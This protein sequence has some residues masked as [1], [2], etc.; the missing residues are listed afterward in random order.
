M[1]KNIYTGI[2]PEKK[3]VTDAQLIS[4]T[5]LITINSNYLLAACLKDSFLGKIRLSD[6]AFIPL[7]DYT[8]TRIST[9]LEIPDTK[10]SLSNIDDSIFIG[11]SKI[12]YFPLTD[13]TN[14]TNYVFKFDI[15]NKEDE[16]NG[17]LFESSEEIISF[18]F[19]NS[20]IIT[21]STRQIS[22]E[23]IRIKNGENNEY[24]LVCMHEG[25][26]QKKKTQWVYAVYAATINSDFNDFE[27][28]W[29]DTQIEAETS[30]SSFRIFRENDTYIRCMTS[31]LL[32]E[33][34]LEKN[35]ITGVTNIK[36]TSIPIILKNFNALMD[37][38]SYNNKFRFSI[39]LEK[40]SF[41]GIS[42]IYS[43]QINNNYCSN[44]FKLYNYQ[45]TNIKNILGY[46]NQN[47]NKIIVLFQTD[48]NIKYFIMDYMKDIFEFEA[49]EKIYL[50]G[51]YE[52]ITCDLNELISSSN[53][54]ALGYLNVATYKLEITGEKKQFY[55]INF[56]DYWISD[57][58]LKPDPSLNTKETYTFSFIDN[59]ENE[60]TRVYNLSSVVIKIKT[61]ETGCNS[62]WYGYYNCTDCSDPSYALLE[63]R[64]GECF[65]STYIVDN[66]IYDNETNKFLKC[67][68]S[69]EFCSVS[70]GTIN[71]QKCISCFPDY[72][73]SY[74]YLGNCYEYPNL[75][76]TED[77]VVSSNNFIF[78]TCSNYKIA[79]T[80]E[81]VDECPLTSPYYTYVYNNVT[82]YYEKVPNKPPKYI[83]KGA[84]HEEC[85]NNYGVDNDNKCVCINAFYKASGDED[86]TCLPDDN[87][88]NEYPYKN[89]DT[90]ECYDSLDKCT[91]FFRDDCYD[92]CPE[93]KVELSS[94]SSDIQNY[95]KEKL[96]LDNSLVDK[97][98]VC[99]TTNG[100]WSNIGEEKI[101]FQKCL[102]SC[103]YGYDPESISKQCIRNNLPTTILQTTIPAVIT[104]TILDIKETT[105]N[106]IEPTTINI[107]PQTSIPTAPSSTMINIDTTAIQTNIISSMKVTE[108][109]TTPPIPPPHI[110]INDKPNC[111][112]IF[113]NRCYPECPPGTCLTQADPKLKTCVRI[114]P[115]T[116]IFNGICF[117]H[118]ESL[119]KNI[120]EMSENNG[121]I[122]TD[123]GII[124]R[125]YS[126]NSKDPVDKEA[127][128][129]IVNL[130]DC[131]YKLRSYYNLTNDT[132]LFI[133]GVDS[134]NKDSSAITNTY[135]YG[136]YLADGTLLDHN[137]V[138]KESKISVS[139]PITNP[140]LI[141]LSEASYFAE[142]G[143]DIFDKNS[144]FYSDVCTPVSIDGND[145]VLSDRQEDFYPSG[146]SLCNESCTYS[147]VDFESN[148]FTCECDLVY[149]FS[150]KETVE[151]ETEEEED[152]SYIEYFLSLINYKI[153]KCYK[154]FLDYKRYYYNAGF[155]IAVGNFLFCILQMIIFIKWGLKRLNI[156]ILEKVPNKMK[157]QKLLKEQAKKNNEIEINSKSKNSEFKSNPPRKHIID[158]VDL[159]DDNQKLKKKEDDKKN[160]KNGKSIHVKFDNEAIYK[161]KSK[162]SSRNHKSKKDKDSRLII[163]ANHSR[164]NNINANYKKNENLTVI[165]S[166]TSDKLKKFNIGQAK[167]SEDNQS[168]LI[169]PKEINIIPYFEAIRFDDRNYA[170]MFLSV[171]FSEIKIIRIFYYKNTF[172]HLSIILSEY[173]FELCLDL[174]LNCLLYTEDVISEKYN[175]NG[176]IKFFTTLSL[177]FMSNIIS[178]IISFF[179]CKLSDY[180]EFFELI[181]HD[182]T[183]KSKYLLNMLKF[184]KYL[185]IKLSAFFIIQT[186]FNLMMCY[187]LMIFCT[188]YHKTQGSIMINYLTGIAESMAISFGL[189][190]I[191]SLMRYL[192]LRCRWK[193]IYYTSKY[194]F[195]KF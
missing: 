65:P 104:T 119:T 194:F 159:S 93:G 81:C 117:E 140:E 34:Y 2:P 170:Q 175:N 112:T 141:K 156:N 49:F 178:S 116:Q 26:F 38:F 186:I 172:E 102:S 37:L 53:L 114:S 106:I 56:F 123:S 41:M 86:I 36:T 88:S 30:Y 136:V 75:E 134:P 151:E 132:E 28:R 5:Y 47:I 96:S 176:S 99:D 125:G 70:H 163:E 43:F 133:L 182:V 55:G 31:K 60:Y 138:C 124:I 82:Q 127:K 68:K 177:S 39:D 1:S 84:C 76:I 44:F 40:K 121:V 32:I 158:E 195:E 109:I 192:S 139:S 166:Y 18:K 165:E 169:D 48:S 144:N 107:G 15:T 193:S 57:N 135:N 92:S 154:L 103:P 137:E 188:V 120:K 3:V 74:E 17:P 174:T 4:S 111:P 143:Y 97:I 58:I 16:L 95:I 69:C 79:A 162:K 14:K 63:D 33:I 42:N 130:G 10:C 185:C 45:E 7:L 90:K 83:Y 59:V 153:I 164:N 110:P 184:K 25:M 149:N 168:E 24:R 118:F 126:I 128:Y 50:L 11:Y 23:P 91:H 113:E 94:Q 155:Y 66:Y 80:G 100:V 52:E 19:H 8:D 21:P 67:Y 167:H 131:E 61:C 27:Y 51:S 89:I 150:Q 145:I 187:Y 181:I 171:I 71:S 62:C 72:I 191:T 180:V 22:C 35:T 9:T 129:S 85:P 161:N 46:Y 98:C 142:M 160:K 148:R 190:L 179:I 73:Y 87:C 54:S 105:V 157:L 183:D 152:V 147:Q 29:M 64:P 13:E 146:I 101:Y 108:K 122:E 6:G 12:E 77:K 189:A 20:T 78:S 173:T 115:N